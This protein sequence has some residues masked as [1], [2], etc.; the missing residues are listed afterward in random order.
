MAK[1]VAPKPVDPEDESRG[2]SEDDPETLGGGQEGHGVISKAAAIRRALAEGIGSPEEGVDFIR[3]TFG[4]DV[5]RQ[6]FSASK[7]QT[8]KKNQGGETPAEPAKRGRKPKSA[9]GQAVADAP[10]RKPKHSASSEGETDL[11]AAMEA[12]KP[13]VAALGADRVKRLVDI[14]G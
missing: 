5:S 2:M 6:H 10:A 8:K 12:M 11:L 14:L 7:S 1:K 3:K 4:L 13:L 9:P